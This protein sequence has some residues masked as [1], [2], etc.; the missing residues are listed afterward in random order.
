[1]GFDLVMTG[2]GDVEILREKPPPTRK[3]EGP[4]GAG[5][6][7]D[8]AAWRACVPGQGREWILL[9]FDW[10]KVSREADKLNYV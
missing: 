9:P 6:R 5:Q 1:M 7:A 4:S 3:R 10:V 2:C 8:G